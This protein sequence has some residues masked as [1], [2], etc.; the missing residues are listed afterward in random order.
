MRVLVVEDDLALADVVSYTLRREGYEVI[1]AHDGAVGFE[2]WKADQPD[3]IILDLNL[4]KMDGLSVCEKIR[5]ESDVPIIILSVRSDDDDVVKG[6][7]LGADDYIA[8]PFSP[9]QLVARAQAVM[10]R[11]GVQIS[12]GP[13][14]VGEISLDPMRHEVTRRG[15]EIIGLTILESKLLEALMLNRGHVLPADALIRSVWGPD[16]A[17]RAMLKQLVYRLR[18]KIE[19]DG[20][21]PLIETVAGVGYAFAAGG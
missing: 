2:R 20:E 4:P 9:R 14:T 7:A 1:A 10:R 21:Q 6:L 3:L 11:A 19:A 15:T 16:G 5:K 8:K 18:K 12:A 13:M 17:D